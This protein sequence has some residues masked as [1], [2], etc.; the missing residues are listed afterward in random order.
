MLFEKKF[1]DP[2]THCFQNGGKVERALAR[3]RQI[4]SDF[5]DFKAY[6]LTALTLS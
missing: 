4:L 3:F 1:I 6:F 2:S 5:T